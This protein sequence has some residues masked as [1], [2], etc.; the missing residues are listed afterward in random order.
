M[1]ALEPRGSRRMRRGDSSLMPGAGPFTA[2]A[3]GISVTPPMLTNLR[4]FTSLS[5]SLSES[6]LLL[7]VMAVERRAIEGEPSIFFRACTDDGGDVAITLPDGE[8]MVEW[9]EDAS[10]ISNHMMHVRCALYLL[11]S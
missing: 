11:A 3:E 9:R 10:L 2:G 8:V 5:L 6:F 4:S 7:Y 1:D